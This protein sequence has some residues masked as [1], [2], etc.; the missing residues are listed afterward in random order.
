MIKL[1]RYIAQ[2]PWNE[3]NDRC[4]ECGN[5]DHYTKDCDD[6]SDYETRNNH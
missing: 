3:F 6:Y 4:G 5:S 2:V 1:D